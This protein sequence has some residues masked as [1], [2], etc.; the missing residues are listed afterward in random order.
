MEKVDENTK[1]AIIV[2]G[3][4]KAI[5]QVFGSI[6][7]NQM[8]LGF[9]IKEM[10]VAPLNKEEI[11]QEKERCLFLNSF[12]VLNLSM[13]WALIRGFRKSWRCKHPRGQLEKIFPLKKN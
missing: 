5:Q 12:K 13:S 11:R 1:N 6:N 8:K 4:C 7:I 3:K 2:K 10:E 9:D